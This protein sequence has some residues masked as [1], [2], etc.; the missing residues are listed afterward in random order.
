MRHH[1][2]PAITRAYRRH[3][4]AVTADPY[5]RGLAGF[6]GSCS[7][8]NLATF[9]VARGGREPEIEQMVRSFSGAQAFTFA[10][11][12]RVFAGR[13]APAAGLQNFNCAKTYFAPDQAKI[14]QQGAA[15]C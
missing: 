9:L 4:V 14:F 12:I 15:Q 3:P 1:L 11:A 13:A 10:N 6:G 8:S 5:R 7:I 2:S